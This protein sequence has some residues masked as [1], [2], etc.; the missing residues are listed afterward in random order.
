MIRVTDLEMEFYCK[1]ID[2][3]LRVRSTTA[4]TMWF[5]V[6]E[7]YGG[8]QPW[9][10]CCKGG[11]CVGSTIQLKDLTGFCK[12]S[13]QWARQYLRNEAQYLI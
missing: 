1:K 7:C 11:H 6:K 3:T 9:R 2:L 5:Q 8:W 12:T 13:R 4:G 10:Q